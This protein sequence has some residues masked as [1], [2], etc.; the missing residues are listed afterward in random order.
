[1]T[2]TGIFPRRV[3][4]QSVAATVEVAWMESG[5]PPDRHGAEIPVRGSREIRYF[6]RLG[7]TYLRGRR[8]RPR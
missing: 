5:V 1:M 8:S 3:H 7:G 6:P 2:P 4:G